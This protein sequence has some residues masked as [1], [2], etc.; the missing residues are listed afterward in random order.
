MSCK[1]IRLN[2]RCKTRISTETQQE[3][4]ASRDKYSELYDFAPVGYFTLDQNGVILEANLTGSGLLGRARVFLIGKPLASFVN[5]ED[6]NALYLHFRQVLETQSKQTC[7]IR[8]TKKDGSQIRVRLDSQ[9]L[10]GQDGSPTVF[11]TAVADI[12][13]R[14]HAEEA[15]YASEFRYRRLFES[16]RDGILIVDFDT[17]KILDVNQYLID[18]LGYSHEEFLEKCLWEVSP[19]QDTA[20]NKE[21]FAELQQKGYIRYEDLPLET[22]DGRSI[23]VE[24]VS[25]SY[26]VNGVTFIQCNIR[27]ITDRKRAEDTIQAQI[28][29]L[30][31]ILESLPHPFYVINANDYTIV[32][33]NSASNLVLSSGEPTCYGL[34]HNRSEPCNDSEHPC[35]IEEV[36]KTRRSVVLEHMH[37][38]KDGN[39]R[40]VEIHA[41]PILDAQGNVAQVIEYCFD[42]TERKQAEEALKS[43]E[44][45]IRLLVESSPIGI[46]AM[47]SGRYS[48]VNSA[49][50]NMLGYQSA[51]E[52]LGLSV[53]SLYA[54]EDRQLVRWR[55]KQ[56][57]AGGPLDSYYEATGL[58][59]DGKRRRLAAWSTAVQDR[60]ER[61]S[62]AFFSDMT[63]TESLRS[64]LLQAQKMEAI[65]TL[66]G[67][68]AHDFNNILQVVLGFSEIILMGK[69]KGDPEYEDLEKV[70]SAGKKGADLVQRLLTFSRKTEINPKPLNLNHQIQRVESILERTIPKIIKIDLILADGLSAI[71]ADPT[72]IEQILM[73]LASQCE[74]CH[75]GGR[76]TNS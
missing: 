27:D 43:S 28:E 2:W 18:M 9:V 3:L 22:S 46:R 19:F 47:V 59:K 74:R 26:L 67:G 16:A 4:E 60:G 20:L 51:E 75:A 15:L 55:C 8:L 44:E 1:S 38:D 23:D 57:S 31:T 12:T 37:Y 13:K 71:N 33:A 29:F 49:F 62:L 48:Y 63:E 56:R 70:L 45:R 52:I 54:P 17:G 35:P 6:G 42:I 32:M 34:T 66:A 7:D 68:I 41:H 65:G 69:E 73:N 61:G 64:Q 11:R 14:K 10:G 21:A 25:N 72:Q 58:T 39:V 36:K 30:N 24:F 50:V 53:E 5:E 40:N 76:E